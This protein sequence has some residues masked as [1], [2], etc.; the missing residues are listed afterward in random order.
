[1]A[2]IA[3]GDLP[4]SAT[5]TDDDRFMIID[6]PGSTKAAKLVATTVVR[7]SMQS[8]AVLTT[9][10]GAANGVA[11][12]GADSKL[13]ASQVPAIVSGV[14]S[15]NTTFTGA[16]TGV[17]MTSEKGVVNGYA[18]LD[19]SGKVPTAQL[20][21]VVQSGSRST[22]T[23]ASA[24]IDF[25]YQQQTFLVNSVPTFS[26]TGLTPGAE[27]SVTLVMD[28]GAPFL[29]AWPGSNFAWDT[30]IPTINPYVGNTTS[31]GFQVREDGVTIVGFGTPVDR[32]QIFAPFTEQEVFPREFLGM[33]GTGNPMSP[34]QLRLTYFKAYRSQLVSNL[35]MWVGTASVGAT[36]QYMCLCDV[37]TSNWTTT[38]VARTADVTNNSMFGTASTAGVKTSPALTA[39]YQVY[40]GK[41]YAFGCS[42]I[43]QSTDPDVASQKYDARVN[44]WADL[45]MVAASVTQA[46]YPALNTAYVAPTVYDTRYYGHL[47]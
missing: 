19:G 34:G 31:L 25:S 40:A 12:L 10:L 5:L 44:T 14:S 21:G 26:F 39:A 7:A 29:V 6:A 11:T 33:G 38:I 30:T 35:A 9:S 43:G 4:L 37:N 20:P 17:Q 23:L 2:T 15:I 28:T 42:S 18:G 45:P 27:T 1:M 24:V 46:T 36:H 13:T 41:W 22:N 32:S 47:V 8:G 3:A 16:V